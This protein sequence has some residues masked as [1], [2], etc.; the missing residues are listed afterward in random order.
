MKRRYITLGLMAWLALSPSM[1][2]RSP[3]VRPYG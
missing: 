1:R 2:S 3:S